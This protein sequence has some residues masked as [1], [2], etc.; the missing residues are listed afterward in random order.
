MSAGRSVLI[1]FDQELIVNKAAAEF[2]VQHAE[3]PAGQDCLQIFFP[4]LTELVVEELMDRGGYVLVKART[5]GTPIGCP[6]D[7]V[8]PRP[9]C[10]DT[11]GGCSRTWPPAGA[12]S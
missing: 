2:I 3:S 7:A 8:S 9:G 1:G 5:G 6:G 4:H 12:G 11:T 10:T